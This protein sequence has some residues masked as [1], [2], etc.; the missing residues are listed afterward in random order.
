[1][2]GCPI[3]F[4]DVVLLYLYFNL[5]LFHD[6][7]GVDIAV[8]ESKILFLG[9]TH[10][11]MLLVYVGR[12]DVDHG[13]VFFSLDV[14]WFLLDPL[15]ARVGVGYDLPLGGLLLVIFNLIDRFVVDDHSLEVVFFAPWLPSDDQSSIVLDLSL[16]Q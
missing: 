14:G 12:V 7:C 6:N 5:G 15:Q 9:I 11:A 1:L 16:S 8:S 13:P 3:I 4:T 10:A 2:V